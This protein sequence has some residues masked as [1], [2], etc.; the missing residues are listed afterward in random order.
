MF[1]MWYGTPHCTKRNSAVHW[2][3]SQSKNN[4]WILLPR[5]PA[6]F[7]IMVSQNVEFH[8]LTIY[9]LIDSTAFRDQ[10]V[11]FNSHIFIYWLEYVWHQRTGLLCFTKACITSRRTSFSWIWIKIQVHGSYHWIEYA[12]YSSLRSP[13]LST[14]G[15]NIYHRVIK[16]LADS[17]VGI[18]R[19][20]LV[21]VLDCGPK[22]PHFKSWPPTMGFSGSGRFSI[23]PKAIIRH[24]LSSLC[25]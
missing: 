19:G 18:A 6:L 2:Y 21:T 12:W 5:P 9:L 22:G 1:V 7:T 3:V 10:L 25:W 11:L 17:K 20:V 15:V 24:T 13:P 23:V 8:N 4:R 14:Y 16:R